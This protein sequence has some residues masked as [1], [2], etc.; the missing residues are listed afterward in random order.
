MIQYNSIPAASVCIRNELLKKYIN[1]VRPLDKDWKME[2]YPMWLWF[3]MNSKIVYMDNRFIVYRVLE[4]SISH[5]IDI[6]KQLSYQKSVINI[7]NYYLEKNKQPILPID[8]N[9]LKFDILI[10]ECL[11]NYNK[12]NY[13][14]LMEINSRIKH[15]SLKEKLKLQIVKFSFL[16]CLYK[17][18]AKK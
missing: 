5:Q 16:R 9:K 8:E 13:Q 12:N 17:I 1:E 7:R 10:N 11:F 18:Y 2:D 6:E 14:K 15:H 3:S 4:N